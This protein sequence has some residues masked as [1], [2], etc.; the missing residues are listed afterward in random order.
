MQQ[1]LPTLIVIDMQKCMATPAAGARNNPQAEQN[2]AA[3]L[4]AWRQAGAAVVH[5]RHISRHASSMFAPGQSGAQFQDALAPL[6]GEH[7]VEKNVPDG[8]V[9]SG[10]ER[11][12]R[13]RGITRLLVAGVSTNN[14][15]EASVRSAGNL[16]F[17]TEVLADATFAFARTDYAGVARTADE[18][19]AMSLA[20]LNGEYATI[21]TTARAL[22]RITG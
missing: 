15:V 10:L 22:A 13:V 1:E 16:G 6:P 7:V 9:N 19:H 11:W 4:K 14:S 20:N 5:L 17:D 2:I 8:F 21:T 18:V 3:L 12:L